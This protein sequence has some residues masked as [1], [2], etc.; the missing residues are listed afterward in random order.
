MTLARQTQFEPQK[1][2]FEC[3]LKLDCGLFAHRVKIAYELV[4]PTHAPLVVVMGGI[5]AHRSASSQN[6]GGWWPE[7]AGPEGAFG[8]QTLSFA[9]HRF[10]G[11][12]G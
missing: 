2:L 1:G 7:V 6:R 10:L 12:R 3:S 5:S 8:S 11:R 4:G 9:R